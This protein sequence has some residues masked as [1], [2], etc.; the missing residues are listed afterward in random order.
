M[1]I[2]FDRFV[3]ALLSFLHT[4]SLQ[5]PKKNVLYLL[6]DLVLQRVGKLNKC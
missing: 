4:I 5:N 6:L 3:C 2:L 1:T